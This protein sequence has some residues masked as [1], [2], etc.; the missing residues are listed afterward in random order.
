[1]IFVM[2]R[3]PIFLDLCGRRSVVI[4]AGPVALRKA[5]ALLSASARLVVIAKTLDDTLQGICRKT[6]AELIKSKY[7]RDYLAGAVVVIAATNN[8]ELNKRIYKD[9][10]E[11]EILCNV[12]D[13]PELCD[14]FVPA[15]IKRGNLQIAI[16]TE[17]KCPAYAGHIRKKIE[18]IFTESHGEFLS[19]LEKIR[20]RIIEDV[21]DASDRKVL[22]G[23]LVEDKSFNYFVENG[24]DNWKTFAEKIIGGKSNLRQ[25]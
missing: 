6:D 19:E 9:C 17:G 7:S 13:D 5:E 21:T 8:K 16:S 10:Q 20:E 2:S 11:L 25:D 23:R 14:F 15:V 1:M 24:R 4:G 22:L 3:Y 12:V 18:K